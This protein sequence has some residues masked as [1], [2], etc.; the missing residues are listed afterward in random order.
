MRNLMRSFFSIGWLG[1][2]LL[3]MALAVLLGSFAAVYNLDALEMTWERIDALATLED[4]V[5]VSLRDMQLNELAFLYALDYETSLGDEL[6]AAAADAAEIDRL[7]DDLIVE[8]HFTEELDYEQEDIDL[9]GEFRA[10]LGQ[11]RHSFDDLVEAY[12]SGDVDAAV[13]GVFGLQDEHEDLQWLL[14]DLIASL[15]AYRLYTAWLFPQDVAFALLGTAI[16]L[17]AML[18]LALVGYHAIARLTRPVVDLTNAVIAIGGDRYRSG[19]VD[20]LLKRGGPAG[21]FARALDAF[22]GALDARDEALKQEIDDLREELYESRRRRL[23]I[24]GPNR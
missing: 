19:L 13:D 8:G 1:F 3:C 21:G 23:K 14:A 22:A 9:L 7:L 2:T 20:S 5:S 16:A 4:Q 11:H 10:M 15:D 6:D 24:S 17:V 12:D 18:L